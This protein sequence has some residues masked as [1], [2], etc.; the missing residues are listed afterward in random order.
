MKDIK[1]A[2]VLCPNCNKET[3]KD[4]ELRNGFK[5]TYFECPICSERYYDSA[6]LRAFEEFKKLR[7]RHFNVKLRMVGNSFSVTIPREIIDFEEKF[8]CMEK[9]MDNMMRLSL[10]EPGKL[11][12]YFK[13]L[14]GE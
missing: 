11:G 3:K 12:L 13:K 2:K 7:E 14:L 8:A 6:D 1:Y 9:E 10:E 5:L 4:I